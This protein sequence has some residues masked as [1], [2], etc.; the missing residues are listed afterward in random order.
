MT[1][2]FDSLLGFK[3]LADV[4]GMK[5][6]VL[7]TNLHRARARRKEGIVFNT[8]LPEPDKYIGSSPVWTEDTILAW[9]RIRASVDADVRILKP[10]DP[11]Q[12]LAQRRAVPIPPV[13]RAKAKVKA[14]DGAAAVSVADTADAE[15]PAKVKPP[16]VKTPRK[17]KKRKKK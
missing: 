7:S 17:G 9:L 5:T 2:L 12:S 15:V 16:V 4:T 10:V 1:S 6:T 13:S 14:N 11:E 3:D 8:D